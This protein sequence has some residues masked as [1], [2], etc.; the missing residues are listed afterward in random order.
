MCKMHCEH[1]AEFV[2]KETTSEEMTSEHMNTNRKLLR[3]TAWDMFVMVK[4]R[5]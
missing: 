4:H 5:I 2:A 3:S 1:F